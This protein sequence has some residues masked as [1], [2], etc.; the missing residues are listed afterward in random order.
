MIQSLVSHW[1]GI[2]ID[3]EFQSWTRLRV[4]RLAEA[5]AHSSEIFSGLT[6]ECHRLGKGKGK[7]KKTKKATKRMQ[8]LLCILYLWIENF[9]LLFPIIFELTAFNLWLCEKLVQQTSD[10]FSKK[11]T[12]YLCYFFIN[13]WYQFLATIIFF[14]SD[15][16]TP[17]KI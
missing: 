9:A 15:F 3:F 6:Y 4:W 1:S 7:Q 17:K 14:T 12:K 13:E 11:I 2:W 5:P 10:T 16:D 8:E